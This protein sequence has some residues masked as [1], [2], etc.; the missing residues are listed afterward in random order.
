MMTFCLLA[1]YQVHIY[2]HADADACGVTAE[3]SWQSEEAEACEY[4]QQTNAFDIHVHGV[5]ERLSH[6]PK[7]VISFLVIIAWVRFMRQT[8]TS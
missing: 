7:M 8:Q 4:T 5:K 2:A 3:T 6:I 1:D